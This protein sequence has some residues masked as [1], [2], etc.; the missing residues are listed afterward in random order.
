MI[1]IQKRDIKIYHHLKGSDSQ[2][3]LVLGLCSQTHP[4]E[5]QDSNTVRPN[6]TMRKQ[7]DIYLTHWK[8]FTKNQS[9]L[10][11]YLA[12]RRVHSG[13]IPDHSD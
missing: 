13:R 10:Q 7:K 2:S 9:K 8:E 12:L 4:T 1:N 5:P 6:H 11:C 3:K